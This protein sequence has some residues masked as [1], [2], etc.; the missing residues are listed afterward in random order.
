[1]PP[2]HVNRRRFLGG[3]AAAGIALAHGQPAAAGEAAVVK[4]AV[5]GLGNRGT[6]L[7]R[8]LV[9]RPGVEVVALVDAEPRHLQR[10]AGI[11]AKHAGGS[12]PSLYNAAGEALGREDIHAAVVALPCDLHADVY[13]QALS[14]NKHLYAEKPLAPTL[15]E[16]DRVIAEAGRRP[17]LAVHVGY[18]RRSH[19]RYVEGVALLRR[20]ELGGLIEAR[21]SWVSSNGPVSGHGGWLAR[22]E[23]SGDWMV[24]QAV[25]MWDALCWIG[26]GLPAT[27]YGHG[28]RDL[29]AATDPGRDVTDHYTAM[30]TWPGGFRASLVHS[31]ADPADDAFTGQGLKVVAEGGGLDL[32]TGAATSR[33]RLIPRRTIHPGVAA[34]TPLALDAF[35]AAVRS[36]VPVAPPVSLAEARDATRVGLLV[37]RA[38]DERRVVSMDEIV[39]TA[40]P[41]PSPG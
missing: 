20:G 29:F 38:V 40:A 24:E 41:V 25:H 1:M 16:C 2:I 18:Q 26:G 23:R 33:D 21:A 11:V 27:A 35:L 8:A 37:R 14:A 10:A 30:L 9:E 7:L 5:V 19:P 12:R 36:P 22:R 15:E 34:D 31:W 39:S 4:V 28:R 3:A 17:E 13:I 32:G 6:T